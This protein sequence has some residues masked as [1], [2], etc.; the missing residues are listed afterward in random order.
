MFVDNLNT[1]F[2]E[3]R[4]NDLKTRKTLI[5]Q[6]FIGIEEE[7]KQLRREIKRSKPSV[8]Q[9]LKTGLKRMWSKL[10][11]RSSKQYVMNQTTEDV[12][13]YQ[14]KPLA[15]DTPSKKILMPSPS[16]IDDLDESSELEVTETPD[17]RV[18]VAPSSSWVRGVLRSSTTSLAAPLMTST[19]SSIAILE[20]G[21]FDDL[22]PT[23]SFTSGDDDI[24]F[25]PLRR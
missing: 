9:K 3:R 23:N 15:V 17:H 16:F 25:T 21:S 22:T 2:Y 4:M 5:W 10:F 11:S 19:S 18:A 14:I 6:E 8:W 24:F 12:S 1:D 13:T 20:F 7:I